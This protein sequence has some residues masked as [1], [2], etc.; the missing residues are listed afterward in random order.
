MKN[1]QTALSN[2]HARALTPLERQMC[3]DQD[4]AW[5]HHDELDRLYRG[6]YL[7]LWKK[8]VVA[9]GL[10]VDAMFLQAERDGCPRSEL[11]LFPIMDPFLDIPH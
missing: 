1:G 2:K 3:D 8:K 4:W 6:Q 10:D 11:V 5:E 9:H 7:L